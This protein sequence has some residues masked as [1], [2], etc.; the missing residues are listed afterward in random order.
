[1]RTLVVTPMSLARSV[2]CLSI[3]VCLAACDGGAAPDAG[4]DAGRDARSSDCV[5]AGAAVGAP[6]CEA[7]GAGACVARAFCA[8]LDGEAP[9]CQLERSRGAGESCTADV[10]CRSERCES[11]TCAAPAC[12]K[13]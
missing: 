13:Q 10:Q 6:C 12:I 3:I 2:S 9:T 8:A 5:A 11:G 7:H 1:A 4:R